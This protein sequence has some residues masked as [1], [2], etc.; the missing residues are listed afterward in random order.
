MKQ[1]TIIGIEK[2]KMQW[3]TRHHYIRDVDIYDNEYILTIS[4]DS[5]QILSNDKIIH[6]GRSIDENN[7]IAVMRDN[8][9]SIELETTYMQDKDRFVGLLGLMHLH[10]Q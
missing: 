6:I 10:K 3:I 1:L 7:T 5:Y 9:S 4:E 8:D 2:L